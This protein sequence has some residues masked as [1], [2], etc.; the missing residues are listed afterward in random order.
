[1]SS[2]SPKTFNNSNVPQIYEDARPLKDADDSCDILT[3][4]VTRYKKANGEYVYY[5]KLST[6][7]N[8]E[9]G[10]NEFGTCFPLVIFVEQGGQLYGAFIHMFNKGGD[11]DEWK[12]NLTTVMKAVDK[13]GYTCY[14]YSR[15]TEEDFE[16]KLK[17]KK[18]DSIPD[19]EAIQVQNIQMVAQWLSSQSGKVSAVRIAYATGTSYSRDDTKFRIPN[20]TSA[21]LDKFE[22]FH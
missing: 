17:I 16:K 1:M 13:T 7:R 18:P 8:G 9:I 3:N 15:H 14:L 11:K 12:D 2:Y 21:G 4:G 5:C 10:S 19:Y 6:N 22:W 20:V